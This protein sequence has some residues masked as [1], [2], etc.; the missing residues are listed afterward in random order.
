LPCDAERVIA[1]LTTTLSTL[2]YQ[3]FNPFGLIPGKTYPQAVRLFVAPTRRDWTRVIGTPDPAL[4]PPLSNLAPCLWLELDGADAHIAAY[5]Q[6]EIVPPKD[7]FTFDPDCLQR[8][9]PPTATLNIGGVP[10]DA[11]PND[12]QNLAQQV[13]LRQAGKLFEKMNV[14]V[15]QKISGKSG[16]QPGDPGDLLRQPDWNSIGGQHVRALLACL[17]LEQQPDFVTL[18]DAY[19]LHERRRR[20]PKAMLYPGDAETLA[21]VPDA[22]T[23]TPVYAGKT[24]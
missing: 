21:A 19:A 8:Q 23:Y 10:L 18:R 3:A 16:S 17:N 2:G 4:L 5:Q 20:S 12:V 6:G 7:A 22:L 14:S 11:L 9:L 1:T 24:P 13:D 15:S